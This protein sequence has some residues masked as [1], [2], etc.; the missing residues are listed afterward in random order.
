M[1]FRERSVAIGTMCVADELRINSPDL[2]GAGLLTSQSV[3]GVLRGMETFTQL[4]SLDETG[5]A[6]SVSI[7]IVMN[8]VCRPS[9]TTFFLA[10]AFSGLCIVSH[11]TSTATDFTLLLKFVN[12][13]KVPRRRN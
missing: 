13:L 1:S 6:V 3:W 4:L 5:T 12:R 9:M 7:S 11:I 8:Q 2:P 10:K